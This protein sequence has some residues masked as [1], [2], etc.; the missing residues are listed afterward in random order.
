MRRVSLNKIRLSMVTKVPGMVILGVLAIAFLIFPFAALAVCGQQPAQAATIE[1]TESLFSKQCG[2]SPLST[3]QASELAGTW[4]KAQSQKNATVST[5]APKTGTTS[6]ADTT[7]PNNGVLSGISLLGA[8]ARC[9]FV[10]PKQGQNVNLENGDIVL[11]SL[12]NKDGT[13]S[14]I[15]GE[16]VGGKFVAMT[17][18]NGKH[19]LRENKNANIKFTNGSISG[20]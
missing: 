20:N 7:T 13:T 19:F 5:T 4:P 14:A 17:G 3:Q 9:T 1:S 6:P 15:I 16:V 11:A 10:T 2:G 18:N 12:E 8:V